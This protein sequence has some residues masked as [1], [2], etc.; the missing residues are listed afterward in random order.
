MKKLIGLLVGLALLG[1]TQARADGWGPF[2]LPPYRIE[3]GINAY[4]RVVPLEPNNLAP[5]YT[6][7]PYE[8]HLMTATPTS[9]YPYWPAQPYVPDGGPA[10][11][12]MQMPTPSPTSGLGNPPTGYQ[13][14]GF[15][16]APSYWYA[17]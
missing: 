13:P 17:R 14:A 8:A 15:V 16:Q 7:W 4:F 11:P 5:W 9:Q 12:T 2:C 6:Y 10:G 1:P 3:A